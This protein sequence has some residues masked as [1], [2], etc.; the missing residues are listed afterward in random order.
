MVSDYVEELKLTPGTVEHART[1]VNVNLRT[2]LI[3]STTT[4]IG[5]YVITD[6]RKTLQR[7]SEHR[8]SRKDFDDVWVKLKRGEN[9]SGVAFTLQRKV[10]D[11]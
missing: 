4:T 7:K 8:L 3:T 10:L 11:L 1:A 2:Q 5:I 9:K 6:T